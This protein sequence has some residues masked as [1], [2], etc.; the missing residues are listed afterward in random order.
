MNATHAL[1]CLKDIDQH[2]KQ[3]GPARGWGRGRSMAG[4]STYSSV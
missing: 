2:P 4:V 3:G 1:T